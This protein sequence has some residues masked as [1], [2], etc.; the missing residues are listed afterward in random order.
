MILCVKVSFDGCYFV[1]VGVGNLF[2]MVVDGNDCLISIWDL[3]SG[4]RIKKM[5]GY[6]VLVL[7][8]DFSVDGLMFVSFSFDC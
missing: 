3:G 8:M 2:I 4:K 7:F 1:L 6:I 5:W